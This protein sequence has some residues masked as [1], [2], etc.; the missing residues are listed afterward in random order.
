[1][2]PTED[3][4]IWKTAVAVNFHQLKNP[5]T[6][7]SCLRLW[8][9]PM[10]SR[11]VAEKDRPTSFA[12]SGSTRITNSSVVSSAIPVFAFH[13]VSRGST[14]TSCLKQP[15]IR[16]EAAVFC[17]LFCFFSC[18]L[19]CGFRMSFLKTKLCCLWTMLHILWQMV[20]SVPADLRVRRFCGKVPHLV[21]SVGT[22]RYRTCNLAVMISQRVSITW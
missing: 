11:K 14:R 1:M 19:S 4:R 3:G 18:G 20:E 21:F 15:Q 13:T 10:F 8:Y 12:S 6:S 7:H 16:R 5:K 17:G 9:F 2:I 22:M